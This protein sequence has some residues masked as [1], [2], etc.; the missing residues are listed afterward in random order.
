MLTPSELEKIPK[1]FEKLLTYAEMRIMEDIIRRIKIN[2]EI[3][4]AADWQIYRMIQLGE[5]RKTIDEVLK[6]TLNLT[7][8]ELDNLYDEIIEEGYSRDENLYKATGKEFI[9]YKDNQPLQNLVSSVKEQTNNEIKNITQSLGFAVKKNGKI[10]FSPIADTYQRILDNAMTDITTGTFDYN[11][12]VKR[13]IKELTDSGLRTVDYATGWNNRVEV[14]ARRAVMTGVN[15]VTSHINETNAKELKTDYFEISWHATA[16]PT[17]Q[18]WQGRVYSR[19][20]LETV[21]GLGEVDGLCGANCYHSY[22]P[23]IPGISIRTYTD[24]QLD[25]M[26]V[27]ENEQKEYN[28][29]KYTSYEATQRQR[30]LETLMRKQRQEIKLLEKA[31]ADENDIIAAKSRYRST[32][33]QYAGFSKRMG[34]PQEIQRVY[35]DNLGNAGGKGRLATG[36][37]NAAGHSIIEVKRTTL[38]GEPNSITQKSRREWQNRKK[39]L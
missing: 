10:E 25:K 1:E 17:H 36:L 19:K 6:R 9:K 22:Y 33:A 26:N 15:Q 30:K 38:I 7:N 39:L 8:K 2:G 28:G 18:I 27:K 31:G 5:S 24:E 21:C 35:A 37:K 16:R 34:L 20:E 14:A 4:R 32:M 11:T 23:F 29:K 3:T 12:V 13:A